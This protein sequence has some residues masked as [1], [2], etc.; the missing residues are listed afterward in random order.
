MRH[1]VAPT[2]HFR[3]VAF[4]LKGKR[5]FGLER[6]GVISAI[7]V[8]SDPQGAGATRSSANSTLKLST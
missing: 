5:G 3:A 8:A 6:R 7:V 2:E 1:A 4:P